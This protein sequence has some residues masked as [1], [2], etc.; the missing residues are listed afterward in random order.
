M[1]EALSPVVRICA[2]S[3]AV[4]STIMRPRLYG[5][6]SELATAQ[7]IDR[8]VKSAVAMFIAAYGTSDCR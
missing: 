4:L 8:V 7:E 3:D 5:A 1:S 6:I 2:A